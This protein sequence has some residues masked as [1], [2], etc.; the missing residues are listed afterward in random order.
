MKSKHSKAGRRASRQN[1][2]VNL[3]AAAMKRERAQRHRAAVMREMRRSLIRNVIA[4]GALAIGVAIFGRLMG[5]R[6]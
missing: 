1:Y 2:C 6:R 4:G 5:V 3:A